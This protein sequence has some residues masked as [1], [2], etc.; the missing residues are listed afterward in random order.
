MIDDL[1]ELAV[2]LARR[3]AG[4]PKQI[5]LRRAVSTAYY[6]VFHALAALCAE[7]LVGWSKSWDAV[8]PIYRTLDHSGARR[9]FDRNRDGVTYG[10][11]VGEIGRIFIQ[12]QLARYTADYDPGPFALSRQE[13]LELI[14]RA[15]KAARL[16]RAIPPEQRLLLA[17]HLIARQR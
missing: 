15:R 4:R 11:E 10:A 8:T 16:S 14:D 6:A 17:V 3:E 9:V 2:D 12:L 13:T 1:L 5:S 7:E